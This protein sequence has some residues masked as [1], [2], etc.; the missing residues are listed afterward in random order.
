M[1]NMFK[2][3]AG[4]GLW[5]I[6][7]GKFFIRTSHQPW[8]KNSGQQMGSFASP[9]RERSSRRAATFRSVPGSWSFSTICV[10]WL[11]RLEVALSQPRT[12]FFCTTANLWVGIQSSAPTHAET[13]ASVAKGPRHQRP[14][15]RLSKWTSTRQKPNPLKDL[16]PNFPG[17]SQSMLNGKDRLLFLISRPTTGLRDRSHDR[18]TTQQELRQSFVERACP[19]QQGLVESDVASHTQLAGPPVSL[20]TKETTKSRIRK[21]IDHSCG[22]WQQELGQLFPEVQIPTASGVQSR[23]LRRHQLSFVKELLGEGRRH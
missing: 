4:F 19:K 14:Q 2:H 16:S 1:E 12:L 15:V 6:P 3:L 10:I 21:R 20:S 23:A 13:S 11:M 18:E 5:E 8:M 9:E 17:P 7:R 22:G